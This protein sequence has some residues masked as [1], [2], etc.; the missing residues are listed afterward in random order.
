MEP[1][2]GLPGRLDRRA[3]ARR[4]HSVIYK[5]RRGPLDWLRRTAWF[6]R[7]SVGYR[8][9]LVLTLLGLVLSVASL[10]VSSSLWLVVGLVSLV[11]S[12]VAFVIDWAA[13]S[14]EGAA[15][16]ATRVPPV[17][18]PYDAPYDRWRHLSLPGRAPGLRYHPDLDE[19][20]R[21][22]QP[23][24]AV[25][26]GEPWRPSGPAAEVW[27]RWGGRRGQF[28]ERKIRLGTDLLPG[29]TSVRL[30]KTDYVAYIVTNSLADQVIRDR[31]LSLP[32]LGFADVGL[33]LGRIPTLERSG[34]SNHIGGDLL[35]VGDGVLWLHQQ[36]HR[37]LVQPGA[38]ALSASGSFDWDLDLGGADDLVTV[39]KNGLLRELE[40]E[41]HLPLGD[42]PHED[43]RIVRYG[44]PPTPA[45]SLSSWRSPAP[46]RRVSP[47]AEGA[48][49][50]TSRMCCRSI[51]SQASASRASPR[52][53]RSR[54]PSIG[55]HLGRSSSWSPR[56]AS[57]PQPATRLGPG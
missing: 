40:E 48:A 21:R 2:P 28:V 11:A 47:A 35:L 56:C 4:W 14:R 12:L 39:V 1:T 16:Y 44:R 51:W 33:R 29:S 42:V 22:E 30:D 31:R 57:W 24:I 50:P 23:T 5:R 27:R 49:T 54:P 43:V 6:V 37:N 8:V 41:L 20:L 18:H 45:A 53:S 19:Q 25:E 32:E 55:R 7:T 26:V 34:C 9:I 46:A 10:V 38:L 36:N 17:A 13:K 3:L 15:L 52:H